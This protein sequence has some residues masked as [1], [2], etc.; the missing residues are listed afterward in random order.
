MTIN[1]RKAFI[2]GCIASAP[3]VIVIVPFS[4]LFGV[5]ATEAGLNLLQVMLFTF[6][7]FAGASQFA[8]VQMMDDGAPVLVILAT[9]LAV[10]LRMVVYSAEF[11]CKPLSNWNH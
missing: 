5:V 3:F 10:N 4:L 1:D 6:S 9:S 11:W 8:A 2:R 7:V